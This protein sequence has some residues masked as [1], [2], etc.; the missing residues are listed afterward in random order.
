M[1][2]KFDVG[3]ALK[4]SGY[5]GQFK[6]SLKRVLKE[7][8]RDKNIVNIKEASYL[9]ATAKV[10]SDYSL[11]RWE[12]DYLCGMRGVAY[13]NKPCQKALNYYRSTSGGKSNY[14]TKGTDGQGLPYFGRGLIQITNKYNYEKYGD[15]IGEDLVKDADKALEKK[16]SYKIAS[17]YLKLKTFPFVNRGELY[18]ARKSVNGSNKGE[19]DVNKEYERWLKILDLSKKNDRLG[20]FKKSAKGSGKI[21]S[22]AVLII[23]G[24]VVA[25]GVALYNVYR[26]K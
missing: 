6:D 16:N 15:I 11:Q 19:A 21:E 1:S 18:Q 26:K 7:I 23:A 25:L 2:Y 10:E 5:N 8:N 17:E 12:A 3:R 22:V 20:I 24:S 14:Y 9:L 4:L 13:V